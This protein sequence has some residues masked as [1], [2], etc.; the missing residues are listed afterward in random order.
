MIIKAFIS[1]QG[2]EAVLRYYDSLLEKMSVPYEKLYIDTAYGQTFV[3]AAGDNNK[4][5]LLLLHGSSMNAAMWIGDIAVLSRHYRVYAP[6][7]PGEPG[8]SSEDQLPLD[9][10]DYNNWLLTLMKGLE[11]ESMYMAGTSL[12]AYL[13]AKFAIQY[14]ERTQKLALLCPAGIGS[15]NPV[16]YELAMELLPKGEPGYDALLRKINADQPIPEVILDYQKLIAANFNGRQEPIPIFSDEELARL[17]MP[18]IVFLGEKDIMLHSAE[19]AERMS[20]IVPGAKVI[21]L[22]D[23]GHSLSGLGEQ[24]GRFFEA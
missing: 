10:D 6:D 11:I 20:R 4:P 8:R 2:K 9:T 19:T 13:A 23:K 16:F 12:G 22:P 14:P 24:I 18:C 7:I 21:M 17:T 3:L 15:Q 1:P 5:P